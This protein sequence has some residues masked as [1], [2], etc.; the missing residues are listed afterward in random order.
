M[1]VNT[2]ACG[3]TIRWRATASSSGQTVVNTKVTTLMIRK[4]VR[5]RSCGPTAASTR[6]NGE[7]V[8]SMVWGSTRPPQVR[9]KRANGTRESAPPGS[10][11]TTKPTQSNNLQIGIGSGR[12]LYKIL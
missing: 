2:R 10:D 8:S 5:V 12:K 11:Q 1:V 4:K 6:D 9:L 3:A 7:M